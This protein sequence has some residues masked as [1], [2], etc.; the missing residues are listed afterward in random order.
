MNVLEQLQ[1]MGF[2]EE[3]LQFFEGGDA[4]SAAANDAAA[5]AA[6]IGDAGP[7]D[8]IGHVGPISTESGIVVD[9]SGAPVVGIGTPAPSA[10]AP[11]AEVLA[12]LE[13]IEAGLDVGGSPTANAAVAQAAQN[14]VSG[15]LTPSDIAALNAA[16]LGSATGF[17]I[18]NPTQSVAEMQNAQTFAN[19]VVPALVS[20][21]PGSGLI[22][23]AQTA[24]GILSGNISLG[25]AVTSLGLGVVANA[26]NVPPGTLNAV[27]NG[28]VGQVIANTTMSQAPAVLNA[29]L[30]ITGLG[31]DINQNIAS[32]INTQLGVT[33]GNTL[34]TIGKSIDETLG[35]T[36]GQAIISDSGFT[37]TGGFNISDQGEQKPPAP[38]PA[39]APAP[40]EKS[41]GNAATLAAL[42]SMG[43][44][45]EE[46]DP[47]RTA[48]I[49]VKS[50]FGLMY[51][52]D[53]AGPYGMRG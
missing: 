23:M 5:A 22:N 4:D 24:G 21:M 8:S 14:A 41:E 39:P 53:K 7:G 6:G 25:Q 10:A 46:K 19:S 28:N 35:L 1:A 40:E 18:N 49:P 29:V 44:E 17:N 2:R 38:A 32:T 37:P 45:E 15:N 11:G 12:L 31:K 51:G 30:G 52:M 20:M 13:A 48:Q 27:L 9:S 50:P 16:G 42:A 34:G 43:F 33:P 26:L 36:P 47:Y 3:P